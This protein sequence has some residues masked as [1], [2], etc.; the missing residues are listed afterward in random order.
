MAGSEEALR[1]YRPV[2]YPNSEFIFFLAFFSLPLWYISSVVSP[3][4]IARLIENAPPLIRIST[5]P[6]G[7]NYSCT[8]HLETA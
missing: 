5:H 8:P 6:E 7:E 3:P 1:A 4:L 2:F